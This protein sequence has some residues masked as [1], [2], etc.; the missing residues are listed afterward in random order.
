MNKKIFYSFYHL[1][2]IVAFISIS[3][4]ICTAPNL[5][6]YS[7]SCYPQCPWNNTL[8]TYQENNT[9]ACLTSKI[10]IIK[11]AQELHMQM[12]QRKHVLLV[13]VYINIACP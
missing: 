5:Y 12:M 9:T 7:G 2:C 6:S 10:S 3:S 8:I 13:F 11:I 4:S 1:I